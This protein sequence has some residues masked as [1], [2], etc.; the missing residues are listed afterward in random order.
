MRTRRADSRLT[1]YRIVPTC[2][3]EMPIHP[4]LWVCRLCVIWDHYKLL[5]G[6]DD[7]K[8][9]RVGRPGGVD[10]RVERVEGGWC[11]G[12]DDRS[13]GGGGLVFKTDQMVGI[14]RLC[15]RRP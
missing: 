1:A 11:G 15:F 8:W 14:R 13:G 9:L 6:V 12:G 10:S 5:D 7:V 3:Q 2:R 4:T